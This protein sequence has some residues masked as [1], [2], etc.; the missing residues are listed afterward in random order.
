MSGILGI[1]KEY[2]WFVGLFCAILLGLM[3]FTISNYNKW[4]N[5]EESTN[6]PETDELSLL[7]FHPFFINAEYRCSVE[8]PSLD[9]LPGKPNREKVFK[10][11]LTISFKTVYQVAEELVKHAYHNAWSEEVWIS[12]V[13]QAINR[14][15]ILTEE[16]AKEAL[17]PDVVIKRYFKWHCEAIKSLHDYALLLGHS[18][19]Y[20]TNLTKMNTFFLIMDLLLVTIL[21]DVE[22]IISDINGE[23]TGLI[24]NGTVLE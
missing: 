2:G 10:D 21:G 15:L 23:L 8:I 1:M 24:Y 11:L 16:R 4:F 17:I 6:N 7:K 22:R 5:A 13:D 9:L 19:L 20:T 3:R 14:T 18:K 12:A